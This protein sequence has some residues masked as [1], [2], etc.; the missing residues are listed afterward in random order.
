[1]ST[2]GLEP[3]LVVAG[4]DVEP[5]IR[6]ARARVAALTLQV[7]AVHHEIE[8]MDGVG[9]PD[10]AEVRR[11]LLGASLDERTAERRRELERE[12]ELER[13]EAEQRIRAASEQAATADEPRPAVLDIR[14][15][16]QPDAEA[17]ERPWS[18]DRCATTMSD[19]V[20]A[21]LASAPLS[22][23]LDT[24]PIAP[25]PERAPEPEPA[26]E[27]VAVSY[28]GTAPATTESLAELL[29][30]AIAAGI[31]QAV[32]AATASPISAVAPSTV[33]VAV[34]SQ[35]GPAGG[36]RP[37]RRLLHVDVVLPLVAA[38]LVLVVLLAWAG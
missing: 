36:R 12:L 26:S 3:L 24:T 30:A 18:T 2:P 19:A 20:L 11:H 6:S 33:R 38:V 5:I 17:E 37:V 14:E 15:V 16:P 31:A 7:R 25:E 8:V 4:E 29:Q 10:D 23:E 21:A 35:A 13:F 32:A 34:A 27:S 22:P 28:P 9:L 1:M